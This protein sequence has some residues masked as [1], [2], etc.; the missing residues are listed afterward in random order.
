MTVQGKLH[1][2][3]ETVTVSE[4][5]RKREFVLEYADNPM[6]PQYLLFQLVQ[7][8]CDLLDSYAVGSE[9]SVDFNLRGRRWDSPQGET[10]YFNSLEAWRLSA[11]AA[12]V[13]QQSAPSYS[14][15]KPVPPDDIDV[16][17]S[18]DDDLPF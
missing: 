5:F 18:G 9:M 15:P 3:Y 4:R 7:E 14:D 8:K 13:Q 12:P 11:V 16:S 6:Y 1:Q 2:K 17:A 10:K